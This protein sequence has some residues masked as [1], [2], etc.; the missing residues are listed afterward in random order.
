VGPRE[1]AGLDP[2]RTDF[3]ELAAIE[4]H[5]AFQNFFAKH[6]LLQFLEDGLGLE[7]AL[8]LAFG[9]CRD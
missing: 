4:P 2:D 6:S 9:D 1:N 3:V 5:T 7:L 8:C